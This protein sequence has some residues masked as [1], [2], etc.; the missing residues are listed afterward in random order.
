M[1]EIIL[2]ILYSQRHKTKTIL[3]FFWSSFCLVN[4]QSVK[5][6]FLHDDLLVISN[7]FVLQEH[8]DLIRYE[9]EIDSLI[10]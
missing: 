2:Y 8:D 3:L 7:E 5:K 10:L 6:A 9:R 1:L 4:I